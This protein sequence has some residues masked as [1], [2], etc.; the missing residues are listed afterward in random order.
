[1]ACHFAEYV[2]HATGI[3][4]PAMLARASARQQTLGWSNLTWIIGDVTNLT[5]SEDSFSIVTWRYAIHHMISPKD[6]LRAMYRVCQP[7]GRIAIADICLP[8]VSDDAQLF[9][10]I[11]RLNDPSLVCALTESQWFNLFHEIGF[12]IDSSIGIKLSF[13]CTG[14]FVRQRL[15]IARSD[16]LKVRSRVP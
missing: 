10:R 13:H 16:Q 12:K 15:L 8:D 2:T 5:F 6:I 14:C 1:M 3:D 7:G 9:N 11:E 4:S